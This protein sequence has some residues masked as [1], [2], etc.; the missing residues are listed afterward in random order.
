MPLPR[1]MY[2]NQYRHDQKKKKQRGGSSS[3]SSSLKS[4][5]VKAHTAVPP[6]KFPL[7]ERPKEPTFKI[8]KT[9]ATKAKAPTMV[10]P[11]KAHVSKTPVVPQPKAPASSMTPVVARPFHPEKSKVKISNV[12]LRK[13]LLPTPTETIIAT[14][15][16][17]R[18]EFAQ[19]TPR[20]KGKC[21]SKP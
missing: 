9:K 16:G 2:P 17:V 6:V 8:P 14:F 13:I 12:A 11:V 10:P 15:N 5:S 18:E 1:H 20:E 4:S 19:D 21:K 7:G 3:G